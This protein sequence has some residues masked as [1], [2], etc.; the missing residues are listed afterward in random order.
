MEMEE[1]KK[2]LEKGNFGVVFPKPEKTEKAAM[3]LAELIDN[4]KAV[5]SF[6]DNQDESKVSYGVIVEMIHLDDGDND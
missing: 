6:V 5:A 4:A 3:D 1:I 2:I